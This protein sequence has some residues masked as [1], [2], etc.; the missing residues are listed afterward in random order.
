MNSEQGGFNSGH[1][2]QLKKKLSGKIH[3]TTAAFLDREGKLVTTKAEI[4]ET[5]LEHYIKVLENRKMTEGLENLQKE[6]EEL[7]RKRIEEAK[8]NKTPE[9]TTK[10]V[11]S[12]IKQLKKKKSRVHMVIPMNSYRREVMI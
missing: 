12:V 11:M 6:R 2:W 4:E 1:L 5:A 7:C 9:W 8:T 3:S 10:D